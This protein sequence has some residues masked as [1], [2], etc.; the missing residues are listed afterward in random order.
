LRRQAAALLLASVWPFKSGRIVDEASRTRLTLQPN[1]DMPLE[2]DLSIALWSRKSNRFDRAT[3]A[4]SD[5]PSFYG[6]ESVD[7][8]RG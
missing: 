1:L 7:K 4:P 2:D 5:R 6:W 3:A 8:R